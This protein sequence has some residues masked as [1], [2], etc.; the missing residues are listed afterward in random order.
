MTCLVCGSSEGEHLSP[1][2]LYTCGKCGVSYQTNKL[3]TLASST[4]VQYAQ[5][6][7]IGTYPI[8]LANITVTDMNGNNFVLVVSGGSFNKGDSLLL[9]FR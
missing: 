9:R 1:G 3:P 2:G 8:V 6:V 4:D 5:D 7:V